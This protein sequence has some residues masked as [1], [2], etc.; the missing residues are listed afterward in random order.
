METSTDF[1]HFSLSKSP[2]HGI[3]QELIQLEY[4]TAMLTRTA[5]K[6]RR[7]ELIKPLIEDMQQKIAETTYRFTEAIK[8]QHDEY[9]KHIDIVKRSFC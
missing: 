7:K 9:Q 3:M 5:N 8:K 6:L 1:F 4:D 2:V